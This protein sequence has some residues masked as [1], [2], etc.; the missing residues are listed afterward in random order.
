MPVKDD[1]DS[2]RVCGVTVKPIIIEEF[3]ATENQ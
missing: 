3:V 2:P 1:D